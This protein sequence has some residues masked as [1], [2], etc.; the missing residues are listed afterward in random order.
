MHR[1]PRERGLPTGGR[2]DK[3]TPRARPSQRDRRSARREGGH[4][5]NDQLHQRPG[6]GTDQGTPPHAAIHG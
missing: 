1:Q 5:P 4:P 6:S 2:R 3:L